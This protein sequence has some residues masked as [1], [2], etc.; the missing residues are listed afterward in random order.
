MHIAVFYLFDI[1]M[2]FNG[3]IFMYVISLVY[4]YVFIFLMALILRCTVESDFFVQL[5]KYLICLSSH[6]FSRKERKRRKEVG[7]STKRPN[8]K[9]KEKGK[10]N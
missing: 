5:I 10:S 4:F 7:R 2:H 9:G 1:K 6:I 8:M 3:Y